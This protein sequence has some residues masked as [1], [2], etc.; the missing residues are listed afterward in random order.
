M[1]G[2]RTP[3]Y[4]KH[5]QSG[6]AR[7]VLFDRVT[8]RRK[9]VLLGAY[10][11]PESHLKYANVIKQ[12]EDAGRVLDHSAPP[13]TE[14]AGR[15][16]DYSIGALMLDYWISEKKR[17]GL[18]EDE[19][20]RGRLWNIRSALR[21]CR[22]VC[23]TENVLSFGPRRLMDVRAWMIGEGHC[24]Q[25]I[26]DRTKIVVSAFRW[27]VVCER[28]PADRLVA[29][30]AVPNLRKGESG[31]PEGGKLSVVPL[32][33]VDAI[34]EHVSPQVRAL[35]DL[36]LYTGARAGEI[37][38]MRPCDLDVTG[39]VWIYMPEHH[40]GDW[41]ENDG[42]STTNEGT[43]KIYLGPRAQKAAAPYLSRGLMDYMFSPEEA[44]A[45]R[46]RHQREARKSHPSTNKTRDAS[47]E[48]N[49][50]KFNAHYTVASYRC[51]ILRACK[52][53]GVPRWTPH[54]LR[55]T[56]STLIRKEH[57][58]EAASLVLG[59][60][61]ALITDAIYAERDAGLAMRVVEKYG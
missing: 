33:H 48:K 18:R 38:I 61:S 14:P 32:A 22:R 26:N 54:Q 58:L 12:W 5:K 13:S 45:E 1:S 6:Q 35:I 53:V 56:A 37:V 43:R 25:T 44:E 34:R 30:E 59:H 50:K 28:L 20:P 4:G 2:Y 49:N 21:S 39:K 23:G 10:G 42:K 19:K 7:V 36:Q 3:S 51:A 16:D 27:A 15:R 24:R 55:H 8:K 17:Y 11:S 9:H 47:R 57:G 31:V 41:R 46:R 40:K 52:K 60:G 29:L